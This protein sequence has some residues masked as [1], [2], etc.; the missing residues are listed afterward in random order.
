[1]PTHKRMPDHLFISADGHM[2]DL[3]V[4]DWALHPLRIGYARPAREFPLTHAGSIALRATI[5]AKFA[6]PG[7][8]ELVFITH[9]GALLCG[10]CARREYRSIAWDRRMMADTGWQVTGVL[11]AEE[12][13]NDEECDHCDRALTRSGTC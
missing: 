1:M 13:E 6:W 9:D 7:G 2:F 4:P 10:D 3:R 11:L 12:L 8:Y 5:R